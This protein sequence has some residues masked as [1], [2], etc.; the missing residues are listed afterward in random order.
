MNLFGGNSKTADYLVTGAWSAK[1]L[2]EAR[3]YG[4][5]REVC[6]RDDEFRGRHFFLLL[7]FTFGRL[8][9]MATAGGV[10]NAI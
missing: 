5:C 8:C 2:A 9:L 7:P 6:P 3:K 1:A 10:R 4:D